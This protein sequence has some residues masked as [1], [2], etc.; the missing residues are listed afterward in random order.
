MQQNNKRWILPALLSLL[1]IPYGFFAQWLTGIFG[2]FFF[3]GFAIS[4]LLFCGL[5]WLLGKLSTGFTRRPLLSMLLLNATAV[6]L[7]IPVLLGLADGGVF[8]TFAL[9]LLS[10][11]VVIL[12]QVS[13]H[14]LLYL[15]GLVFAFLFAFLGCASVRE[16][17]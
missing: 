9:P 13:S 4:G 8:F 14:I 2:N 17:S 11:P 15:L 16:K 5:W 12:P 1:V 3:L 10:L 6:L 7:F